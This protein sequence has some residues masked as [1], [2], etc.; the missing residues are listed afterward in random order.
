[1]NI[2]RPHELGEIRAFLASSMQNF[3]IMR[4]R[5]RIGKSWLLQESIKPAQELNYSVFFFTGRPQER[6]TKQRLAKEWAQF[7]GRIGPSRIKTSELD[8]MDI[9]KDILLFNDER[10]KRLLLV[11]DEI[12]WISPPD[13]S[14]V[15]A[16]KESWIL[17]ER[18]QLTKII[19]CGSSTKWFTQATEGDTAVLRGMANAGELWVKPFSLRDV[20][21]HWSGAS[22]SQEQTA[23]LY[24]I[25]GGIPLYLNLISKNLPFVHA[26]NQ[27][28]FCGGGMFVKEQRELLSLEFNLQ[29][30]NFSQLILTELGRYSYTKGELE[31]I[32]GRASARVSDLIEKLL[33]YKI[34]RGIKRIDGKT[35]NK[36]DY[37][38]TICD[39]YLLFYYSVMNPRIEQIVNNKNH[40]QLFTSVFSPINSLHIQNF[41]GTAFE[42]LVIQTLQNNYFLNPK[43]PIF[44]K[45]F[46][47]TPPSV[48]EEVW[49]LDKAQVA[50]FDI[51]VKCHSDS[52]VRFIE[53]KWSSEN[54]PRWLVEIKNKPFPLN[55]SIGESRL[56]YLCLL[57][58]PSPAFLKQAEDLGVA[59][60][61]LE[62]LF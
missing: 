43:P 12:Q 27:A 28:L 61:T 29:G 48:V 56:N 19:V 49:V 37:R 53:C 31:K 25:L 34:L 45:L 18:Q 38:Y 55:F 46:L 51:V 22:W 13:G 54:D 21:E 60:I 62:E 11:I 10:K 14:F 23:L 5:R 15:G 9:L 32:L 7:S 52:I 47:H 2:Y 50:Q 1:M 20:R 26:V 30:E 33:Q 24:M 8:W 17:L 57:T 42:N 40:G 6:S 4:G 44:D 36:R 41:T 35:A 58:R 39:P 3:L 59:I 16:L